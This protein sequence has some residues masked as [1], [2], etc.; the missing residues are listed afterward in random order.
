MKSA[1]RNRRALRFHEPGKFQ[2]LADRMRMKA[3]LEKLQNEISQIAEK[4]GITSATKLGLITPKAEHREEKILDVEWWDS[5][6]LTEENYSVKHG[7]PLLKES[8]ITNFVEHPIQMKPHT[9]L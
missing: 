3:Q 8:A 1:I 4:T 9:D 7:K 5:V 6:I 2:Q